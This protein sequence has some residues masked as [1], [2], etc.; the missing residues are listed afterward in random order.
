MFVPNTCK[1]CIGNK[2]RINV[3]RMRHLTRK[4]CVTNQSATLVKETLARRSEHDPCQGN[5]LHA[6]KIR[7]CYLHAQKTIP[8]DEAVPERSDCELCQGITP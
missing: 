7:K 5:A 1:N 8:V 3:L 2:R 4:R 6:V